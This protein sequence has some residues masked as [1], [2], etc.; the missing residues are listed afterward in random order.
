MLADREQEREIDQRQEHQS[1]VG[2]IDD[3]DA[4]MM[5]VDRNAL[6]PV[7]LEIS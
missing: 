2:T 1:M 4:T 3:D 6:R 5:L 7:E